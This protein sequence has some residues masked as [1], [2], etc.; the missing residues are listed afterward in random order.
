MGKSCLILQFTEKRFRD[1]CNSTIEA[2]LGVRLV[3]LGIGEA[4]LLIGDTAGQESFNSLPQSYYRKAVATLLVYDITQRD[5]FTHLQSWLEEAKDKGNPGLAVMLI[6]NKADLQEC[7]VV[8]TE[9]G[10]RFATDHGLLFLETSAKDATN[11]EE[12]FT[13]ITEAIHAKI[14]TQEGDL[15]AELRD[16]RLGL[17]AIR[18]TP[19]AVGRSCC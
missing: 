11:V 17:L 9:E 13:T 19:R 12:A 14:L 10:Q 8:G 1:D 2:A 3:P 5:S 15:P 16:I 7:R 6:G 18:P 4:E